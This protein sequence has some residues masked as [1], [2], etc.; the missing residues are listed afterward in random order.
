MGT[1]VRAGS[2]IAALAILVGS[3]FVPTAM[4]S[5]ARAEASVSAPATT[6]A[7]AAVPTL[8]TTPSTDPTPTPS[9]DATVT[10][11]A[12]GD[13]MCHSQQFRAAHYGSIYDFY[14][15]FRPVAARITAA[16]IAAGN[17]ETTL[18]AYGPYSGYPAFRT[19][20]SY[21]DGLKKAG[22]DVLTTANNH[23]LD[24]GATG[25]RATAAYL[26]KLGIAHTGTD[27]DGPAIVE[28][29]GVKIAFLAYTYAT[30]GIHSPFPGAVNRI[31][32]ARMKT[33][34][35]SA[36]KRA[37]L[38][39]VVPHWGSEYRATPEAATRTL[40]RALIDAGADLV[41]GSH[42]HVVRPVESYHGRFIVY[43]MGNFISGM[44]DTYTDLGIMIEATIVRRETGTKVASLKVVPVFRDRTYGAGRST[45]RVVDIGRM[46]TAPDSHTS[47]YDR[48]RMRGYLSY[49]R[50]MFGKLLSL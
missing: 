4:N 25:V 43:S 20:R 6:A 29:D 17:L 49:C 39:I 23:A 12:V 11:I 41:L 18:R 13:L 15:A 50:R 30:N 22:F 2:L 7:P 44:S 1:R 47:S 8:E 34:I 45:Y 9:V 35:A 5:P 42:P 3:A 38:V 10:L 24:G 48:T 14:P 37:D 46:L 33:N 16:D 31:S 32:L 26:D 21:A 40:A 28:H 27:N 19:P 36:R